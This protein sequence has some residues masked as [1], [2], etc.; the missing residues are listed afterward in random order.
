VIARLISRIPTTKKIWLGSTALV[1]A[2][3]CLPAMTLDQP[4]PAATTSDI[5]EA[6]ILAAVA[7]GAYK[8]SP[9]LAPMNRGAYD[10]T[11]ATGAKINVWVT[12]SDFVTY[13]KV[14]PERSGSGVKLS[15]GATIVREVLKDGAVAK[16][17]LM[18][19]GP[20]GYN[21]KLGDYWFAV[22]A[23]DGTPLV[24]DGNKLTG[25][26]EQCFG[27][28]IPRA[29]DDYLFGVPDEARTPEAPDAGAPPDLAT[30]DL[31]TPIVTTP[32]IPPPPPP[33]PPPPTPPP[34]PPPAP[35][36]PPP[37]PQA[38]CGDFY[39]DPG[40]TCATCPSDCG[41]CDDHGGGGSSNSGPG[42][43]GSGSG[44]SGGS[45]KG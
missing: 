44:S 37:P 14:A 6:Q 38:V 43:S 40:E 9:Q 35:P 25:K 36:P 2:I 21:P 15:V 39:C 29:S 22:T 19:K 26:L 31:S 41:V 30:P 28:H 27:C 24:E 13:G 34:P 3:G 12:A 1:A 45:G 10:S 7:N 20:P 17:T 8:Y 4:A 33:T 42:S 18:S 32:P 5:N 23:P 16:L 11:A